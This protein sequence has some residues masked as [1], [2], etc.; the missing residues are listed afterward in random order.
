MEDLSPR[1]FS[2]DF[3]WVQTSQNNPDKVKL[4]L[5]FFLTKKYHLDFSKKEIFGKRCYQNTKGNIEEPDAWLRVSAMV[6]PLLGWRGS[7]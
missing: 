2:E 1:T 4:C 6:D 3:F 5:G 7:G